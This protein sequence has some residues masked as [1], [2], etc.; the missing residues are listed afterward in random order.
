MII[1]L[2]KALELNAADTD[3]TEFYPEFVFDNDY[4]QDS[5]KDIIDDEELSML[6]EK[7]ET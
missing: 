1:G 5:E 6:V 3:I 7:L 4:L 2:R